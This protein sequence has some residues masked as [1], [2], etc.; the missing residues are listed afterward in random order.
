MQPM[1]SSL[2]QPIK[3]PATAVFLALVAMVVMFFFIPGISFLVKAANRNHTSIGAK[4]LT[5]V[6]RNIKYK[7]TIRIGVFASAK[8]FLKDTQTFKDYSISVPENQTSVS[9][10]IDDL[11]EGEYAIALYQ[12][13]NEDK[14]LNRN[15]LGI[16][17]E[18]FGVSNNI[19]PM[20]APPSY[21]DCRFRF[22]A[23]Q[24]LT[25]GLVD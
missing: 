7:N 18:P 23:D 1:K 2:L 9:L 19:K 17:T 4:K 8:D 13:R 12:D 6:I 16:P 10:V 25:I 3:T 22:Y 11:P 5:V 21:D 14:R 20:F 24:T 15:F